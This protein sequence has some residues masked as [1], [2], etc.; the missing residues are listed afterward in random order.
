MGR[1]GG[2]E[3]HT[4]RGNEYISLAKY[5][6]SLSRRTVSPAFLMG[7]PGNTQSMLLR[8]L[9]I[10]IHLYVVFSTASLYEIGRLPPLTGLHTLCN[11]TYSGD[12]PLQSMFFT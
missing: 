1:G 12:P 10:D 11:I 6:A 3:V 4:E 5:N 9:C 2:W 7:V 8:S